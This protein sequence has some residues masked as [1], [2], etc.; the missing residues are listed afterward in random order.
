MSAALGDRTGAVPCVSP[1]LPGSG[2]RAPSGALA[3][4]ERVTPAMG[5]SSS[6][7]A[8]PSLPQQAN[9]AEGSEWTCPICSETQDGAAY[10]FPCLHQFC[11]GCIVRWVKRKASCP[12]CR[13]TVWSVIY[14]V[15][16]E[17]D[18]LE[19]TFWRR[20]SRPSV[21]RHQ[22]NRRAADPVPAVGN[23]TQIG[24]L[25]AREKNM[26]TTRPRGRVMR[27]V[28]TQTQVLHKQVAVQVSA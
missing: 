8:L 6:S 14:S 12:L 19:M 10:A 17:E 28:G 21:A 7:S 25:L 3:A 5:S 23:S 11:L 4:A 15:R 9:M 22:Y 13:Q 27:N 1:A 18:F 2:S 16:S 26:V 24:S 20:S